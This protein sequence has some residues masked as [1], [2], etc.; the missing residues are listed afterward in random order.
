[1]NLSTKSSVH[2][3]TGLLYPY[4]KSDKCLIV[5]FF[6]YS[7]P[8][9]ITVVYYYPMVPSCAV[10]SSVSILTVSKGL[11]D[12]SDL[13]GALEARATILGSYFMVNSYRIACKDFKVLPIYNFGYHSRIH[14]QA[15]AILR[16]DMFDIHL[17]VA[18]P[19]CMKRCV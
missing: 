8:V 4:Y 7:K 11:S 16:L 14:W 19:Y 18:T 13:V 9:I 2:N 10:G 17:L 6:F 12:K 1:M 3:L 5:V 15:G